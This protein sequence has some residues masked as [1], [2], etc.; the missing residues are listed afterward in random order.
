[1]IRRLS[2]LSFCTL[3][4]FTLAAFT[5]A[6]DKTE[7]PVPAALN[8][9]MKT[10]DGKEVKLA[11]YQGK[12]ILMVNVAS[13]CGATPQYA[14]LQELYDSHKE[15]GLVIIGFPCNQFGKQEPGTADEIQEFCT[16]K[17]SVTFPLFAKI[18]V[19]GEEASPLYQFLTD[20]KTN[21]DHAGPIKW[22]F[23]KFLISREG[24]VV[25]RFATGIE[26]AELAEQVA[27]E[28]KK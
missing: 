21:P 13:K 5:G 10:L 19:N 23:E 1:M 12:V 6:E 9:T 4:L 20:K 17:Y 28:L 7:K 8:F 3:G 22:N 16:Q 11:D 15:A 27:A 18:D 25:N 14:G 24:K 26:P 2:L